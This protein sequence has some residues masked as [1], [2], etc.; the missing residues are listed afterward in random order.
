M[1]TMKEIKV[2]KITLNIGV[3]EAGDKLDKAVKLLQTITG[4]TPVKTRSMKRIPSWGVRPKLNIATKVTLRGEKAVKL[5]KTLLT[6]VDNIIPKTKFDKFGNF[7]FGIPE[8]IDIPGVEYDVQIGIIGLEVAVT[9]QRAGFRVKRRAVKVAKL[10]S[11]HKITK[12][13]AMMFME[14]NFNVKFGESEE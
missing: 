11:R 12:E 8:Y 10:P 7:S 14:K 13:E 9:L 4:T 2:E 3:G 1:N 5:L 6:A